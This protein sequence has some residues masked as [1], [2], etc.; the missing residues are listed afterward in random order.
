MKISVF[1]LLSF[2]TVQAVYAERRLSDIQ[3]GV[4]CSK[5]PE[6]EKHLGSAELAARNAKG[7]R[8]YA[9]IQGGE[10]A[11]IVYHCDQERLT[12]QK[13]IITSTT[14]EGAY[15]FAN[16]QKIKLTK[17]LGEPIHDGLDLSIGKRL[18]FAFVGSDLD[19]LTRVVVWG[20]A[21][22]DTMLLIEET[23]T[24]LWEVSISQ[25]SSKL[26]YILNS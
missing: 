13:I 22:E 15:R 3:P 8:V 6:I 21:K 2:L 16:E 18:Y 19:H 4:P 25:G 1:F 5:I 11:T 23:G 17:L 20:R 7:I 24:N 9:G 26:K 14:R 12:E 10:K